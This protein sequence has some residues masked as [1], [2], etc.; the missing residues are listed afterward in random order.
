MINKFQ[1]KFG[2][3]QM[4]I[5]EI[6]YKG[7]KI[8][9][10]NDHKGKFSVILPKRTNINGITLQETMLTVSNSNGS[11]AWLF[12]SKK[13]DDSGE[14]LKV[15][16]YSD[17]TMAYETHRTDGPIFSETKFNPSRNDGNF[18]NEICKDMYTVIRQCIEYD[19]LGYPADAIGKLRRKDFEMS[20][21][22]L[23][24]SNSSQVKSRLEDSAGYMALNR[25]GSQL[26]DYTNLAPYVYSK[27]KKGDIEKFACKVLH[28]LHQI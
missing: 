11:K 25:I 7:Q 21:N 13:E 23:G 1:K 20:L 4:E 12:S 18:L 14:Y 22:L 2:G 17:K 6:T 8:K 19:I 3:K 10:A 26:E 16:L 5:F 27:G 9:A 24:Y 28:L 15:W